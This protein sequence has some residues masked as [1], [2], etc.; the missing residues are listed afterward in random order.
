MTL[1]INNGLV[2]NF[3]LLYQLLCKDVVHIDAIINVINVPILYCLRFL[4]NSSYLIWSN[5]AI[6]PNKVS[7]PN[8]HTHKQS[9]PDTQR[10]MNGG[11]CDIYN[12]DIIKSLGTK[13]QN[14]QFWHFAD[15]ITLSTFQI[16]WPLKFVSFF[17]LSKQWWRTR[18]RILLQ[19]V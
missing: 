11:K 6:A 14:V 9:M 5:Q 7:F 13:L 10:E 1:S 16:F 15:A 3:K 17:L 18:N 19:I 2:I 4:E 12:F 8:T